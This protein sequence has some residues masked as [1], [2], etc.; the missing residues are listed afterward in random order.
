MERV[1]GWLGTSWCTGSSWSTPPGERPRSPPSGTV[2]SVL[3]GMFL[4]LRCTLYRSGYGSFYYQ[5]KIVIATV[6]WLI[7]FKNDVNV[8]L[9]S[10]NQRYWRKYQ[11]PESEP[12]SDPDPLVWDTDPQIRIRTKCH[13]SATPHGT[14]FL[15]QCSVFIFSLERD[16][17]SLAWDGILEQHFSRGSWV[18][19][20]VFLDSS[21]CLVVYPHFSFYMYKAI[22][23]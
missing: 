9:N 8:A 18:E 4:F 11:D 15:G 14:G 3:G 21:L 5:A 23:E 12:D 10:N 6:L 22:H 7:I 17:G 1:W 19:T 2:W 13:G 20:L 16:A